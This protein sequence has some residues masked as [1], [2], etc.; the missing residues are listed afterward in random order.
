M[1]T[2]QG[3]K[4]QIIFILLIKINIKFFAV[5]NRSLLTHCRDTRGNFDREQFIS[6]YVEVREKKC[7]RN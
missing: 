1:L 7:H 5:L 6:S 3:H 2:L 4:I